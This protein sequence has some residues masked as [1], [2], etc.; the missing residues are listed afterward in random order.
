M[1]GDKVYVPR[2]SRIVSSKGGVLIAVTLHPVL[3]L[4]PRL[5]HERYG[6]IPTTRYRLGCQIKLMSGIPDSS[7]AVVIVL[8]VRADLS[9]ERESAPREVSFGTRIRAPLSIVIDIQH[10]VDWRKSACI[11]TTRT[12][13]DEVSIRIYIT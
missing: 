9:G 7:G 2:L 8:L 12:A 4:S 3:P 6:D 10:T 1:K 5:I 11:K 13:I